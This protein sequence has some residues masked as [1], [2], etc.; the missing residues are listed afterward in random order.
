MHPTRRQNHYMKISTM[1]NNRVISYEKA[2]NEAISQEMAIDKRVFVYGLD[3]ADHKRIFGT[4][5]GLLEKFGPKRCFSTPLSEETLMGF[6]IGAAATGLRPINI[7]IRVDF[8]LLAMNQLINVGSSL[9]YGSNGKLSTP[10]VIISVIG[11]GWGQGFQHS[12]SLQSIFAHIPG[13][14]V[15]MPSTPYDMKGMMTSAIRDNNIVVCLLHRWLYWVEGHVPETQYSIPIGQSRIIRK[16]TDVT[17]VATSWMNVEAHDAANILAK[18][19]ISLEIID[20]RTIS[21]LDTKPIIDS[22][23]KTGH[24]IVADYDWL[25]CGFSAEVAAIVYEKCSKKLKRSVSRI[26]FASTPCPTTRPLENLFYP[27][28]KKI[29]REVEAMLGLPEADL[30]NEKFHTW[31]NKFKGPF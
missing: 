29:I 11:R 12:K 2:L 3:V 26:G 1:K 5:S 23:N 24:C 30:S 18:R 6:G 4:T 21:P 28:A 9:R 31:E 19:G 20:P 8:L 13:L 17:V 14:K 7:H 15:I 10:L 27:D 25:N 22:V 16:G